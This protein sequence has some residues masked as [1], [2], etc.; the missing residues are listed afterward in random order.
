VRLHAGRAELSGHGGTTPTPP[1]FAKVDFAT[2][3]GTTDPL[4]WLNQCEQFFRGQHTLVSDRTWLASYHLRGAAQTW[5]Y[6]L[7]QDEG[8][9]PPGSV[10]TSYASF[11]SGRRSAGAD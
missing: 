9:M 4:N 11:V 8:G 6:S 5:Y 3:D 10:F 7:E 2:Y 1:R